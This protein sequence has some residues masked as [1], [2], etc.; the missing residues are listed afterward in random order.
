[1]ADTDRLPPNSYTPNKGG[2]GRPV[3][4][5]QE[6]YQPSPFAPQRTLPHGDVS[7]DGKRAWPQPSMTSRVLTYGGAALAAAAVTA[8]AVLAVRK[9][10]DLVSGN[11][12][13][14]R[15]ADRAA[16]K[17]RARVYDADRG[18]APAFADLSERERE[19]MRAR[20]R[21]RAEEDSASAARL[22]A[23]ANR[24][25]GRARRRDAETSDAP[26]PMRARRPHPPQANPLGFLGD[27]DQTAQRLAQNVNGVVGSIG[28]ALAAFRSVSGQAEGIIR[29]F[30][31]TAD[32]IRGFLNRGRPAD[33]PAPAYRPNASRPQPER[34]PYQR[35]AR[36]DVVDLRDPDPELAEDGARTHRL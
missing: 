33:E 35:P 1:M 22:R 29:D 9:V 31:D 36:R 23:E 11:D 4:R 26:R 32:Q 27:I 24:G 12:E 16:E 6:S 7:L 34:D 25:D 21:R 18:R 10:A 19:A 20:A 15:T 28:A 3:D 2:L 13:L 5:S 14:D 30:G 8:G 17:A